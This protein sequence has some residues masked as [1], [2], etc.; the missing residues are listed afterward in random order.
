[1][2]RRQ[3]IGEPSSTFAPAAR[4][5][6]FE[7]VSAFT[8]MRASDAPQHSQMALRLA[9]AVMKLSSIASNEN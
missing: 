6:N 3:S 5:K 2:L 9:H 1:M 4:A 8:H 7:K